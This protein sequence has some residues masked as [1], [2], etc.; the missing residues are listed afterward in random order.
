M[1]VCS[2]GLLTCLVVTFFFRIRIDLYG[3]VTYDPSCFQLNW[4]GENNDSWLSYERLK[5]LC[6]GESAPMAARHLYI[7]LEYLEFRKKAELIPTQTPSPSL[8]VIS[9]Q[10]ALGAMLLTGMSFSKYGALT[11][12]LANETYPMYR[13]SKQRFK[14]TRPLPSLGKVQALYKVTRQDTPFLEKFTRNAFV[15]VKEHLL[16]SA[17]STVALSQSSQ[18][19]DVLSQSSQFDAARTSQSSQSTDPVSSPQPSC[20]E[21]MTASPVF[22]QSTQNMELSQGSALPS[23]DSQETTTNK[24]NKKPK[25]PTLIKSHAALD[26]QQVLE[27][28]LR[29]MIFQRINRFSNMTECIV[30]VGTD[31]LP[32][33]SNKCVIETSI[34]LLG[35]GRNTLSRGYHHVVAITEVNQESV[36]ALRAHWTEALKKSI[37]ATIK[38]DLLVYNEKCPP[39]K[40]VYCS[41]LS[42]INKTVGQEGCKKCPLCGKPPNEWMKFDS[43]WTRNKFQSLLDNHCLGKHSYPEGTTVWQIVPD[44]LHLTIRLVTHLLTRTLGIFS[45]I[46]KQFE[47][48]LWEKLQQF[49]YMLFLTVAFPLPLHLVY[50]TQ[51][52]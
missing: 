10:V 26:I 33:N 2:C 15:S 14:G 42:G 40:F 29:T 25:G 3:H 30:R 13:C 51:R 6:S 8:P 23:Q 41:D 22:L 37:V 16:S 50:S 9:P 7:Y 46:S 21:V 32:V 19:T 43:T 31:A 17:L 36:E 27:R 44:C 24:S 45:S 35:Y 47:D 39:I 49:R 34:S 5:R 11:S 48:A 12:Y 4:N 38:A 20:P 52:K 1:E 28:E 18:S